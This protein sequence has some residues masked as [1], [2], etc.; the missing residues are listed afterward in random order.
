MTHISDIKVIRTE[1]TL[2]LSQ[3]AEKG[4]INTYNMILVLLE[5]VYE[6]YIKVSDMGNSNR[7]CYSCILLGPA[8]NYDIP[9]V[10]SF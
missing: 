8:R 1:A 10:M 9:S 2:D 3:K 7:L 4:M 5:C 6:I